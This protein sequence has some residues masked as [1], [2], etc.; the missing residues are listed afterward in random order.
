MR[1]VNMF[2]YHEKLQKANLP[3]VLNAK[4]PIGTNHEGLVLK[5]GVTNE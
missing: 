1:D 3:S 2:G 5:G 4:A